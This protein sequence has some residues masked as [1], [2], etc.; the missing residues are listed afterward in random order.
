MTMLKLLQVAVA[1]LNLNCGYL[2][3]FRYIITITPPDIRQLN[4]NL[5]GSDNESDEEEPAKV[6]TSEPVQNADD[7][8][9]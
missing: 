4:N 1:N 9:K 8:F 7:F 3:R 6:P 2:I 5:F